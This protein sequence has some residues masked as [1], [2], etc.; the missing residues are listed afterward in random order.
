MSYSAKP[1]TL[2]EDKFHNVVVSGVSQE[3]MKTS[4]YKDFT[5]LQGCAREYIL[6]GGSLSEICDYNADIARKY[7]KP[8]VG[9][10]WNFVKNQYACCGNSSGG[11]IAN[12][13]SHN[14]STESRNS[15]SSQNVLPSRI[16][17]AQQQQQHHQATITPGWGGEYDKFAGEPSNEEEALAKMCCEDL[18]LQDFRHP[19]SGEFKHPGG[20]S[21]SLIQNGVSPAIADADSLNNFMYGEA[22]LTVD[23]MDCVKSLRNGFLYIGPHD[24]TKGWS[25]PQNNLNE[26][27]TATKTQ[28]LE[29]NKPDEAPVGL[30]NMSYIWFLRNLIL[31]SATNERFENNFKYNMPAVGST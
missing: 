11:S 3:L 13:V 14:Q 23:D 1:K 19:K 17:M 28:E 27:Q 31:F 15:T 9:M 4:L 25:L 29:H 6:T 5:T 16:M 21:L 10:L 24:L 2:N 26:L 22:E 8:N 7:G 12:K 30:Q 20:P 18:N